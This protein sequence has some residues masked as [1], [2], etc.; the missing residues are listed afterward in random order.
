MPHLEK[1]AKLEMDDALVLAL[2][3]VGLYAGFQ[4][5]VNLTMLTNKNLLYLGYSTYRSRS[6]LRPKDVRFP[7][8]VKK[9]LEEAFNVPLVHNEAIPYGKTVKEAETKPQTDMW[10]NVWQAT[11]GLSSLSQRLGSLVM[12]P[13]ALGTGLGIFGLG[14]FG[15]HLLLSNL[16][17]NYIYEKAKDSKKLFLA[18]LRSSYQLNK[19]LLKDQLD[20]ADPQE[21]KRIPLQVRFLAATRLL[22]QTKMDFSDV[23]LPD[24][25]KLWQQYLKSRKSGMENLRKELEELPQDV[26]LELETV[27]RG[28]HG[29]D[30]GTFMEQL[31]TKDVLLGAL[32]AIVSFYVLRAV[33]P[34]LRGAV[35]SGLSFARDPGGFG[36]G[37]KVEDQL[38]DFYTNRVFTPE[39]RG[40]AIPSSAFFEE[41]VSDI[42]SADETSAVVGASPKIKKIKRED[43]LPKHQRTTV[44]S[45]ALP[46]SSKEEQPESPVPKEP[47]ARRSRGAMILS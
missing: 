19:S 9:E 41:D 43:F 30:S 26:F 29:S 42:V 40:F 2:S 37:S 11:A 23:L 39:D 38:K 7:G 28:Q 22:H 12:S 13:L 45:E 20:P 17:K 34:A 31:N 27:K 3:A 47:T 35:M 18:G 44:P 10:S 33:F 21:I 15:T 8:K 36:Y 1:Q 4:A 46:S 32:S 24:E 5:L 14:L 25:Q 6:Q 16:R